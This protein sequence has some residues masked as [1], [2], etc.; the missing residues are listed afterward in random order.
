MLRGDLRVAD[1]SQEWDHIDTQSKRIRDI[2]NVPRRKRD[3]TTFV[4]IGVILALDVFRRSTLERHRA[5]GRSSVARVMI[6]KLKSVSS[7]V[8]IDAFSKRIN[9]YT[10]TD[11]IDP[12]T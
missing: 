10:C 8:G 2:E 9:E 3:V 7:T 1:S 5:A 11:D 4:L 6:L 12:V